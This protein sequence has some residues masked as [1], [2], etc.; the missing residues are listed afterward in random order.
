MTDCTEPVNALRCEECK[1]WHKMDDEFG[2]CKK[3]GFETPK[4]FLGDDGERKEDK[5]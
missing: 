5:E 2:L 1:Y 3:S 4:N